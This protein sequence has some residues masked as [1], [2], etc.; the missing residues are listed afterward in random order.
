MKKEQNAPGVPGA[1]RKERSF[2]PMFVDLADKRILVAGGGK[3]ARRRIEALLPFSPGIEVIAEEFEPALSSLAKENPESL[4]LIGHRIRS[5]KDIDFT[6][7]YLF[8]ACT[9]EASLNAAL[10]KAAK[11][12][13]VI[14][15]VCT[16]RTLC[17]FYFPSL[18][19]REEVVIGI[20]SGGES[21]KK[22][23][24]MRKKIEALLAADEK[25]LH[26]ETEFPIGEIEMGKGTE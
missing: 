2:F 17:D 19:V 13:G 25:M 26:N 12:Q 11:K 15:N 3:I 14:V 7:A 23:G 22:T 10:A 4:R 8:L 6:G 21:P 18:L 24:A 9:D 1:Q 20:G 16:D 5:E